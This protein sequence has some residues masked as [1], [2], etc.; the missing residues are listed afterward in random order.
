MTQNG[1][2]NYSKKSFSGLKSVDV[3]RVVNL[4]LL[5]TLVLCC[6][7]SA[8]TNQRM[9]Q[10]TF[11]HSSFVSLL[12]EFTEFMT[13]DVDC[14]YYNNIDDEELVDCP[15]INI[16]KRSAM[17]AKSGRSSKAKSVIKPS[18]YQQIKTGGRLVMVTTTYTTYAPSIK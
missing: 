13:P 4:K 14:E 16:K 15:L 8:Q 7:S 6:K 9:L 5:Y 11:T 12:L 3:F 1:L 17:N 2:Q 10:N 18:K